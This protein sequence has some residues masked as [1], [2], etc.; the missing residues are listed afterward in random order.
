MFTVKRFIFQKEEAFWC[1]VTSRQ[2]EG[3]LF[4]KKKFSFTSLPL[5]LSPKGRFFLCCHVVLRGLVSHHG[6]NV[7]HTRR[8]WG[9]GGG[10]QLPSWSIEP[11]NGSVGRHTHGYTQTYR[12]AIVCLGEAERCNA[13]RS[14]CGWQTDWQVGLQDDLL[15][16]R[17]SAHHSHALDHP[18][19]SLCSSPIVFPLSHRVF[20]P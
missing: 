12:R 7:T 3:E 16:W 5:P 18:R 19:L 11:V 10:D 17:D 14:G 20:L 1:S 8:G 15:S 4:W 2:D 6:S 13:A 9:W